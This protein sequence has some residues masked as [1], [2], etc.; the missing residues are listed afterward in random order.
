MA[1]FGEARDISFFRHINRELMGN[2]ISQQCVY[3]KYDLGETKVNI[4]GESSKGKYFHPP[5][6]LNCLIERSG[7]Q[8]PEND[9][10]VN[11]NWNITFKFFRDGLLVR[12]EWFIKNWG[13]GGG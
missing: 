2:I 11:F 6:Q 13:G 3:Y 12:K 1:L 4:Y 5:V 10:G 8:Y 7:Q 9:L